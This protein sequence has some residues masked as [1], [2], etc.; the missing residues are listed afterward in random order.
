MA[1]EAKLHVRCLGAFAFRSDGGW[2]AGPS[3]KRGREL[4]QYLA[5]YPR[6]AASRE[7]LAEAFW[8]ELDADAVRHRLHLAV[9]GARAAVR[10]VVPAVDAIRYN[11][12]SYAWDPGVCIE[13]DYAALF[14]CD[15]EGTIDALRRGIALYSGDYCSGESAEW[16]YALRVRAS[17]M[18][19]S[20]LDRLA[21]DAVA[22]GDNA[23]A[24]AYGLQLVEADRGHEGAARLVMRAFAAVGRRAAALDEYA[25]LC[26][27]LRRHLNVAPS[28]ATAALREEIAAGG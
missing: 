13:T 7:T 2:N 27:W 20:M 23:T 16:M 15:R 26:R 11:G 18:Y 22:R 3:F 4:L 21:A 8:P 6:V 12:A 10:A 5:T 28:R 14:A 19:V 24:L 9:T 25:A 17:S 1:T